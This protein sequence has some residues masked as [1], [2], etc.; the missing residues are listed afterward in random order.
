MT[1]TTAY[2]A[3]LRRSFFATTIAGTRAF[4]NHAASC[5]RVQ[6][7]TIPPTT[8]VKS[9][10]GFNYA[11]RAS[12][13]YD[14]DVY[15]YR[16]P[17][18]IQAE[19]YTPEELANRN[20]NANLLRL[21]Y[22]FRSQG[23]RIAN[24]DPL[25]LTALENLRDIS[26]DRYG[27]TNP[28]EVFDLAGIL[29]IGKTSDPS[30]SKEHA[31]LETI[32]NHL[33]KSYCGRIGF[34]FSHI[35]IKSER[36]WFAKH[37][38]S[39]EKRTFSAD[40]KRYFSS[41]LTKSEVFDHFMARKFPQVKRYGLQ[42]AESMMVSDCIYEYLHYN[43][44]LHDAVLCMPHRGRLNLLSDLLTYDPAAIFAKVKGSSEAPAELNINAD[45]L[46]HLAISTDIEVGGPEKIHVSMLHNPSHLEAANPVALGKA[47]ARQMHLLEAGNEQDCY[48]G[49]RVMCV[50]LH[51]DAAFA[52][53][54]V[55]TETLGLANLPH[56]TAG[57]SVHL[58]VNN[59]IG[60]TTP[61]MNARSTIYT[62]DVGKMIN[63]PVIHVNG[64]FP[65]DV[66]YATSMAF[67]YRNKFHK[68]I[69]IDM[70]AYR[71]LGHN[72]LDE[73]AFT[74]PV[75]YKKIRSL[76]TVPSKYE[77]SLLEEGVFTSRSE[78]DSVR[79]WYSNMEAFKGKWENMV[80]PTSAV[81][82]LDTGVDAE[83][84]KRVGI[85]S[86]TRPEGFV[87]HSR[88]ERHHIAN[89]ISKVNSGVGL[90][91]A[92]AEAM[93]FGTLL[94]EG[95]HVRIS[96][97]DVGRGTFSQRHAMLVDSSDERTIIP[98]NRMAQAPENQ[99]KLEIANS[100]LSEYA[101]LGFE[102]GVSW[103]TPNRLCIWEAQFGDFYNGA[104]IIIDTCLASG[105]TK[106]LRQS[107][108]VM[109]LPHGYDGAGPEHSSCHI[110]RFLQLCDDRF[111]V[112]G[113]TPKDC[114]PNMH[115]VNPTTPAQYFHLLRRQL[116][117]NYRKPLIVAGPKVLLR[118]PSA[119][120]DL[121]DM[122][123][124]TTFLPVLPDPVFA[125]TDK[126]A[127]VRRVCFISG[128]LYYD[129]IKERATRNLDDTVAFVRIEEICP[130]PA[131]DLEVEVA[132]FPNATEYVYV[133]EEAQNQG[134]YTFIAP[135]LEQLLPAGAKL[136][137][138]GRPPN[139][140][141][142]TGITS[143]HKKE[144]AELMSGAFSGL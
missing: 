87:T 39:Y 75:M 127:A 125:N 143:V 133:Q 21:V 136:K 58:I 55:V 46:S 29:H 101:V 7:R 140:A 96:G 100:H 76:K 61:A 25:G 11:Q 1:L 138:H 12:Y 26:P 104:Q 66:A 89:R 129:M 36:L 20:K 34:E 49:D 54:G 37:V 141:V 53:Q 48:I 47:R 142:A 71:R 74:Q 64:D 60:Y 33:K 134:S 135:R 50:Q 110:E 84:L 86:V 102:Y 80:L 82:K 45:V 79:E 97:Q 124:G 68:D 5:L 18:S 107:G 69:I 16:I 81:T 41:L 99:G 116:L 6:S 92:T 91:W 90:D 139:A 115:V 28:N 3:L 59:Q 114:N 88:L 137:Y 122:M 118:H 4:S 57:G 44:G 2:S 132:R 63:C 73:P 30:V 32:L 130:F 113:T 13:Y 77:D 112:K 24:I 8:A 109:L 83:K 56:Y 144:V 121:T 93:A 94:L 70:I 40:E 15:G 131:D 10:N 22:A 126:A 123:P 31:S 120:S 119:T 65:E 17:R 105:E 9:L 103:E 106:W 27:L 67:E 117:R 52:G 43:T 128:K 19:E 51:G 72:E 98:L 23:H 95:Y 38:E 85:A 111:D 35:P 108:L 78:I 42:G 14:K 62:S